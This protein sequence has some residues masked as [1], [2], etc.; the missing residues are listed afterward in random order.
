MHHDHRH[1]LTRKI[2]D[3]VLA[4]T[5]YLIVIPLSIHLFFNEFQMS[6]SLRWIVEGFILLLPLCGW[7]RS[8]RSMIVEWKSHKE[9][10]LHHVTVD[11][12]GRN[13]T[14]HA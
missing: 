4:T 10:H 1:E 9:I 8:I 6:S 2:K 3:V 7:V 13:G 5:I 11:H 14:G 12:L